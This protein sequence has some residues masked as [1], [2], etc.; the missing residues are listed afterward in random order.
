M[1]VPDMI[2]IVVSDIPRAIAFYKLLGLELP[3]GDGYVEAKVN[4]YRIS[5]NAES[6]V[7]EHSPDWKKPVGQRLELAFLCGSP[8]EVDEAYEKIVAAGHE[9]V[10]APWDAFWGQRYAIVSDPD[11]THVSLF[12]PLDKR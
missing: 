12:A 2:G 10:K 4:G 6:M 9:G 1:I 11:G 7:K 5:L 3:N 8:K